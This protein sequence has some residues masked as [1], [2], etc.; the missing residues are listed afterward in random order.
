VLDSTVAR[1]PWLAAGCRVSTLVQLQV[2]ERVAHWPGPDRVQ[3]L[4]V[5]PARGEKKN[6]FHRRPGRIAFYFGNDFWHFVTP[7]GVKITTWMIKYPLIKKNAAS[8]N[9]HSYPG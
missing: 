3:K 2:V 7:H 1:G 8:G 5:D 6:G 4:L 9:T